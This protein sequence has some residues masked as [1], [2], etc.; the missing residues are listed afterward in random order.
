MDLNEV[1]LIGNV[2][3]DPK[4]RDMP[5]GDPM[6]T[7]SVA[8]NYQ[9]RDPVTKEQKR[10]VDYHDV[11]AWGRLAEICAKYLQQGTKVWV[12]GRLKHREYVGKDGAKVKKAEVALLT[13]NILSPKVEPTPASVVSAD[14][15]LSEFEA[16]EQAHP[17]GAET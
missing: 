6:V 15:K 3:Q 12:R 11:V 5:S 4:R 10:D 14:E 8:T 7:F 16:P 13:L 9:W 1:T 17:A 2:A